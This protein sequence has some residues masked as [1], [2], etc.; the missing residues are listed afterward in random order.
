[1]TMFRLDGTAV[2]ITGAAGEIGSAVA[3]LFARQGARLAL[4][5][6]AQD[7][8]RSLAVDLG[9]HAT[10]FCADFSTAEGCR[11]AVEEAVTKLGR[12]DVLVNNV[13]ICPRIPF[14]EATEDD[15]DRIIAVNQKSMFFCSLYAAP[16]L[17]QSKGRIVSLASYAGRAGAAANA[18]I[19]SG[20]K[21]AIIAMTKAI[22][23]ELAPDI[24]V[25]AV[26]PG[27]IDT[28]MVRALPPERLA[29][30]LD[31]VPLKR[32]GTTDE[33]AATVLFLAAGDCGYLTGVTLDVN[34][35]WT[36]V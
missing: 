7:R 28:E 18:S 36:M 11:A 35:G 34:G 3:R 17:Q 12:L 16:H 31:T 1:M 2:L 8:V 14:L 9:P 26:A 6:I 24:L 22:A 15:W 21:G 5:D 25:N 10:A 20:T 13:G 30:L 32:L 23:R 29:V 19:Y 33:V 27:A 4:A